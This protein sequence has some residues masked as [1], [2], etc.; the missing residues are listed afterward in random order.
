VL[1]VMDFALTTPTLLAV[2]MA[3]AHLPTTAAALVAATVW[4]RVAEAGKVIVMVLGLAGAVE[5][6]APAPLRSRPL[7]TTVEPATE[8]TVP[9]ARANARRAPDPPEGA[10]EGRPAGPPP[11]KPPPALGAGQAA[12]TFATMRTEVAVMA[13]A[14]PAAGAPV[15]IT[16]S[17]VARWPVVSWV[18]LVAAV[19]TTAF[20]AVEDC[21]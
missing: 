20:C 3:I 8:L 12:L 10:P 16:Q 7:T 19:Y 6:G 15:T 9:V 2:P 21:T 5:P 17:P 18:N 1:I 11:P 4:V 14:E 13:L